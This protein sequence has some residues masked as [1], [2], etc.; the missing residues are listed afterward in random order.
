[1]VDIKN[2]TATKLAVA[3]IAGAMLVGVLFTLAAPRAEAAALTQ[4]QIQ[5]IVSLLSSFGADATTIANVTASLNGQPT[6]GGTTT[7]GSTSSICPFTW[8]TNLKIG[9]T[10]TDVQ[11][12]QKFLNSMSG[13]MVSA[14]GAGSAGNETTYYGPATGAAVK[15][16]QM[17]YAADILTPLGL[18]TGTTNFYSSTRAK[19]NS[20]CATAST[21]GN[22]GG[23]GTTTP[24]TGLSVSAAAEPANSYIVS[25]AAR[26][27]FT[28]FTVTA[29]NDGDVVL[30]SVVVQRVGLIARGAFS[31]IVLLD[32]NGTIVGDTKT[33]NSNDQATIGDKV[34]IPRGTSK[35]FTVAG[36]FGNL[37]SPTSYNGQNGG[38]NVVA[39]NTSASVSGSLPISG[40]MHTVN[41]TLTIGTATADVSSFDPNT[42][43]NQV[44]GTTGYIFSGVRITAGS[45]EDLRLRS[46][47]WNQNG[48][49]G[50]SDM[51]NLAV[52]VDG[53]SYPVTVSNDGDYFTATFGNGIVIAQGLSKDVYL[54]GDITGSNASTRTVEFDIENAADIY[55]TGEKYGYG[56]VPTAGSTASATN[57]SEFTSGTPFFSGS[58]VT[59][60]AG[61]ATTISR[62]NSVP[63]QN[64]AVNV[65][66]QPLGGFDTNFTG[67]AVTAQSMTFDLSTSTVSSNFASSPITNITLVD[68][69][70]AVVAGP[71]DATV[72]GGKQTLTFNDSVTFP[73]G[74]NTYTLQ[75]KIPSSY[76]NGLGITASTT[77]GAWTNVKGETTGD[78]IVLGQGS[79]TMN[80]MTVKTA[81]L[82]IS[83]SATPANQTITAGSQNFVFANYQFD[84]TA[85]G[86]DVRF[87]S[88]KLKP[89]G[90]I[91]NSAV[92]NCQLWDG[93]TA[94]NTGSNV[95]NNPTLGSDNTFT[96]D[97]SVVIPKGT[98]K[99][100]SLTCNLA[101]GATGTLAWGITNDAATAVVTGVTSS[102]AVSDTITGSTGQ[103]MTVGTG[104]F[105]VTKDAS[106]PAYA[107]ASGGST[108]VT[109]GVLKLHASNEDMYLRQMRLQLS[110]TASSS[111]SNFVGGAVSLYDGTTLVG[112][113]IFNGSN[114]IAT[115]TFLGNGV[116]LPKDTDKMLTVKADLSPIG[117]SKAGTEGALIA[118]DY[119]GDYAAGTYA[120]GASSGSNLTSGSS[121]D[122]AMDG[123]RVFRSF[124]TLAKAS[125]PT[126]V[127]SNG[128]QALMR[129]T[130]TADAAGDIGI[131]KFTLKFATTSAD[132]TAV[133]V[134][135]YTD[136]SYSTPVSG[137]TTGGQ[138][139]ASNASIAGATGIA[140]V[141]SQNSGGT[142]SPLQIPAGQ[143][144]YFEVRATVSGVGS[145]SSVITDLEGDSAYPSLSGLMGS[146]ADVDADTNDDFIWSPNATGTSGVA[147]ND[148]TNGFGLVGLPA[149][150]MSPEVL[151]K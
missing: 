56:V 72:S 49:I 129:F 38:L 100:L 140:E 64:I 32:Q 111:A 141:Y 18:T 116:L 31:G 37:N 120:V 15:K 147:T 78:T 21:G 98:S 74:S 63:A 70:G 87:S 122:T 19:A 149:T 88:I 106:S 139:M 39:V 71:V 137:V 25:N 2:L 26:V 77:P 69:N 68:K 82:A 95:V 113:A 55:L 81:A 121:S 79:F 115:S 4:A 8:T 35:T 67:E 138:L 102:V 97:N 124:P 75:G 80:T 7:G 22:N 13:T 112:T 117:T 66:N 104:A 23:T 51:S 105:A 28:T 73:V 46:I 11:M 52:V 101:G 45:A 50:A 76:D 59:V 60:T 144:R 128:T 14:S 20:L 143:T 5:S 125:V 85:S 151:S 133:N 47:R 103:T 84:A 126:N 96:L 33:L 58:V 53:V 54:K 145:G 36:N 92:T 40:A 17:M 3:A 6:T 119:D 110:N 99:T 9:S 83:V 41:G 61:S 109:L 30:N 91:S 108:G 142:A 44:V 16:F 57:A 94:L 12:L 150:N 43:R 42:A 123:V 131:D 62:S 29:G 130:V 90:S 1:M 118:V 93:S 24:G 148:W 34:T 65:P 89:T 135:G 27:P 86:E 136:S 48:S 146:V 132:V 114:T 134:F 10:G 127:L 107:V